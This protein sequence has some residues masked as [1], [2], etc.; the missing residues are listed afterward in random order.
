MNVRALTG[1]LDPGWPID[2]RRVASLAVVGTRGSS[3]FPRFK[4][5]SLD[6]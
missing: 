3:M 4:V 6:R 2:P 1:F 5:T